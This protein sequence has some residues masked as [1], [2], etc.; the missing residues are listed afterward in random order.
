L[1]FFGIS[2]EA[3]TIKWITQTN[4]TPYSNDPRRVLAGLHLVQHKRI[5]TRRKPAY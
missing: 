5:R 4:R 3:R 2:K 1:A